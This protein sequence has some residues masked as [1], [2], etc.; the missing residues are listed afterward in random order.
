MTKSGCAWDCTYQQEAQCCFGI[1]LMPGVG[2]VSFGVSAWLALGTPLVQGKE[3]WNDCHVL[4]PSQSQSFM[5]FGRVCG[6]NF[7][8]LAWALACVLCYCV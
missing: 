5:V 3:R 7:P 2:M 6:E 4:M 8:S 1:I